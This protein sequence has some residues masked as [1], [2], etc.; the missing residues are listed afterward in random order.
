MTFNLN[1]PTIEHKTYC[2]YSGD[3]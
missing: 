2:N 3:H 1:V